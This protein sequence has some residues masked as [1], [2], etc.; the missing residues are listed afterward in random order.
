[1][2]LD[3]NLGKPIS[4]SGDN[5]Y[6]ALKYGLFTDN[7]LPASLDHFHLLIVLHLKEYH[8]YFLPPLHPN[9]WGLDELQSNICALNFCNMLMKHLVSLNLQVLQK[10][11]P[12][13]LYVVSTKSPC[14]WHGAFS[15][16]KELGLLHFK[17][18]VLYNLLSNIP[19]L[20]I[21]SY[22]ESFRR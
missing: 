3:Q 1:M 5:K 4:D 21:L 18:L 20:E 13:F 15:N 6:Q 10:R 9:L 22:D 16:S 11:S 12:T 2:L 14:F 7:Y 8:T 17:Y 19:E